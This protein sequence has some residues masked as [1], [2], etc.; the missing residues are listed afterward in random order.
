MHFCAD[1]LIP[2]SNVS[3]QFISIQ[4]QRH[5]ANYTS[6]SCFISMARKYMNFSHRQETFLLLQFTK[7]VT[8]HGRCC[9]FRMNPMI[10][11]FLPSCGMTTHVIFNT[12]CP[13]QAIKKFR[14]IRLSASETRLPVLGKESRIGMP[15][16]KKVSILKIHFSR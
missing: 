3:R 4:T 10:A 7:E 9:K 16:M 12:V 5:K 13:V 15:A 6:T 1:S 11:C 14:M 2:V 8:K